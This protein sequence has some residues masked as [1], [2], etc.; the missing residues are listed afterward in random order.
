ME[1]YKYFSILI[2]DDELGSSNAEGR[3]LEATRKIV[4][5]LTLCE[6][7]DNRFPGFENEMHGV[8]I[9]EEDGRKTYYIYCI[10]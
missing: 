6:E 5:F 10:E 8:D 9:K 7:F 4:D 1:W 3:E 2:V